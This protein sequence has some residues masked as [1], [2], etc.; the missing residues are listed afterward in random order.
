M[1][2]MMNMASNKANKSIKDLK[3]G[4]DD[5]SKKSN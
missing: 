3:E 2:V 5:E 4:G 1:Q